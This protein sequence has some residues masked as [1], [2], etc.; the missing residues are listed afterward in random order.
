MENERALEPVE[1]LS[2]AVILRHVR[3]EIA[4]LEYHGVKGRRIQEREMSASLEYH[5]EKGRRIQEGEMSQGERTFGDAERLGVVGRGS[6]PETYVFFIG[7]VI[8]RRRI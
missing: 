8:T 4:S 7:G 5:G 6:D 2:Q 1:S 3:E